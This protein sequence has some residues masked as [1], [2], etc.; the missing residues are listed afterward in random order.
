[1]IEDILISCNPSHQG[2]VFERQEINVRKLAVNRVKQYDCWI[3]FEVF[4]RC[5]NKKSIIMLYLQEID[6]IVLAIVALFIFS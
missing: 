3:V 2:N 6:N 5:C 1:M 4:E